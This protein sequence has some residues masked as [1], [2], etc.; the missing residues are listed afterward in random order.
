MKTENHN[1]RCYTWRS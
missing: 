1:R